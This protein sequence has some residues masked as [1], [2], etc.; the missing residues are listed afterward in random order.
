MR[1]LTV[2]V[3]MLAPGWASGEV[4]D[5]GANGFTVKITLNI[6]ASPDSVY[7]K[8]VH[9]VG[10]WWEADHTFSGN[11]HNLTIEEKPMGCFC[12]KLPDGG[13][14]RHMEVAYF[15]PGKRLVLLGA[16]GP[17]QSMAATGSMTVQLSPCGC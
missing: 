15:A 9:N 1:I 14:V 8:F 17:L 5:S 4:L 16:L 7:H 12:E 13:G 2:L 10:D 6:Q 11:S 3:F